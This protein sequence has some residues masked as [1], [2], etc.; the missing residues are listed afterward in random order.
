MVQLVVEC[1]WTKDKLKGDRD[2]EISIQLLEIV[3]D[4]FYDED[5]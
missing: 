3:L 1:S 4:K 5:E 2:D